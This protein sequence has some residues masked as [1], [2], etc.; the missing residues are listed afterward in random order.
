[1]SLSDRIKSNSLLTDELNDFNII[2]FNLSSHYWTIVIVLH[3][4]G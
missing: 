2:A 1:M 3:D 4:N